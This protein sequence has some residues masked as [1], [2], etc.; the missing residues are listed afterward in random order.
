MSRTKHHRRFRLGLVGRFALASLVVFVL[1]ALGVS[2]VAS[3]EMVRQAERSAQFHA[4]Y[5][6]DHVMR[7]ALEESRPGDDFETPF[8]GRAYQRLDTLVRTRIL[9]DPVVRVKVYAPD[10]TIIYSDEPRLVGKRFEG[11]PDAET[12]RGETVSD[13]TDLSE[14]ENLFERSL[15]KQL[16]STYTP[17]FPGSDPTRKP[18]A[19]V[20]TYQDYSSIQSEASQFFRS[21]LLSFGIALV[22][23]YIALLPIVLGASRAL[24]RQNAQ[25]EEQ[26]R[27]LSHTLET[28][29][30]SV[31]EL[32]RLN[33]M[34]SDFAAVASHELRT[35]LTAILGYVKTL[36]RP[37]F[38]NDPV[39]R[40]E[41]LA[42]IERQSDRLFRLITNMLTAAQ[43]EHHDGAL[44]IG[45]VPLSSVVE[46]VV[47]GFHESSG[48]LDVRV[49]EDLPPLETDR[50][51][52]GEVL[53]NL[54]DNA[55]KYSGATTQVV[56]AA[57]AAGGEMQITVHD[58]GVGISPQERERIFDRF[59]QSDQSTTRRFGGVGLGLHLVRELTRRLGG[60][61]ALESEPG[62][63]TTFLIRLPILLPAAPQAPAVPNVPV[64]AGR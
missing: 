41:F 6:A 17:L 23:L 13:V 60:S 15:A 21:R 20:E 14:P 22:V 49:A 30:E 11:E 26:A 47:E 10:G 1:I 45:A 32:R 52:L 38:E 50:V 53:A 36:R 54:I 4:V 48:R 19:I 57:Q 51:L 43:V 9:E 34:Q 42:A 63:G 64:R 7:F 59:Y 61:V 8:T 12:L 3:R 35:P 31:A 24:R 16:F 39:A 25:L 62:V 18:E 58:A 33:K 56:V 29:Q 5:V 27:R 37:E 28:E 46:E 44:Q 55:L 2:F 40:A